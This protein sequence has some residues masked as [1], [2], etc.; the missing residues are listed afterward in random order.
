M[1][2]TVKKLQELSGF[3]INK[4]ICELRGVAIASEQYH[5]Y[6]DRDEN[7]V[8]LDGGDSFHFINWNDIMP[9]AVE[10]GVLLG[11]S[12]WFDCYSFVNMEKWVAYESKADI[13]YD[14]IISDSCQWF[15][16]NIPQRAIACCL[17]LVLQEQQQ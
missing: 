13:N 5:D 2:Y 3:E 10:Y 16:D 12:D 15:S 4:K 7:I 14:M 9:L 8:L 1:K 17:I 11:H 6:S